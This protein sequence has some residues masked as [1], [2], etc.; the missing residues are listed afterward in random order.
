MET[1]QQKEVHFQL[2]YN[3]ELSS[4]QR[5]SIIRIVVSLIHLLGIQEE[6]SVLLSK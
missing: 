2:G 1:F 6:V 5:K 3:L 4:G